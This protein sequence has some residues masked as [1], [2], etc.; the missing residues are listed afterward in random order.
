MVWLCLL[1][2]LR[3]AVAMTVGIVTHAKTLTTGNS[4]TANH[5]NAPYGEPAPMTWCHPAAQ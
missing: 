5:P 4:R 2:S 3:L 1:S